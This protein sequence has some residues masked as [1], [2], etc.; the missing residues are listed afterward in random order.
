M[1]MAIEL[2]PKQEL[3]ELEN[4]LKSNQSSQITLQKEVNDIDIKLQAKMRELINTRQLEFDIISKINRIK[5][6]I[7]T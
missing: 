7:K 5:S 6:I 2:S 3:K 4:N 1:K